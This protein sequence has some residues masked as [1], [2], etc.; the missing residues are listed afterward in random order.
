MIM[1]DA[2]LGLLNT[3]MAASLQ[4]TDHHQP[5]VSLFS[6]LPFSSNVLQADVM[7]ELKSLS[8]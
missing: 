2:C 4:V 8:V 3:Q 6:Y 1:S 5:N 7:W